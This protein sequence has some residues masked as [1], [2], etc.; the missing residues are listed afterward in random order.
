MDDAVTNEARFQPSDDKFSSSRAMV[1]EDRSIACL[2]LQ[3]RRSLSLPVPAFASAR[4]RGL[5]G[6]GHTGLYGVSP[7]LD[8]PCGR[9]SVS[10]IGARIRGDDGQH[11]PRRPSHRGPDERFVLSG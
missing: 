3:L 2:N 6:L 1:P 10:C 11:V 7:S 4:L 5:D 9:S 8:R